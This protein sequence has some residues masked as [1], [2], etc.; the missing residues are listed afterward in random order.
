[1][2][3]NSLSQRLN[4]AAQLLPPELRHPSVLASLQMSLAEDLHPDA[5]FSTL[6]P[7][8]AGG[9]LSSQATLAASAWLN[10][11]LSAKA[12]GVIAGLPLVQAVCWLVD[13]QI[14]FAAQISE[15]QTVAAGVLLAEINGPGRS[16]L[17][18]ER[19]ALNYLGRLSGIATLAQQFVAAVAGT[20]AVILDTR[21]TAPG[22]RHLDK[23]AV[24]LGGAQ[25][26]RSGLYDMVM[27]KDNHIDGAGGIRPA[28]ERVRQ[29]YG[30]RYAIEVEVKNLDE[31]Q[32]ALGLPVQRIM[33]DNMSLSDMRW[34]VEITAG[35]IPLE[36]SGNVRLDTV[37]AIAET[38]VDFISAGALTHSAPAFDVS[39]RLKS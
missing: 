14:Q 10:G 29:A 30:E 13:P 38:G 17:A 18:A 25:N 12:A 20:R 24:K 33:L 28:V 36:A 35:R 11:R 26:H 23:Y 34:A 27:I 4:E 5:D 3:E 7:E 32:I 22:L 31:L 2:I 39:L 8:P 9:D 37:R 21:K 6:W 19:T 16:L 15:G 1:M